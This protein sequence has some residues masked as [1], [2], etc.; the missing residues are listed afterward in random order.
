MGPEDAA[1]AT[2]ARFSCATRALQRGPIYIF[3]IMQIR[4]REGALITPSNFSSA[5]SADRG[6]I[7]FPFYCLTP[8]MH[9]S[10]IARAR[11]FFFS[12]PWN[13]MNNTTR[14]KRHR[15]HIQNVSHVIDLCVTRSPH[16]GWWG[17]GNGVMRLLGRNSLQIS[18]HRQ[19]N[20]CLRRRCALGCNNITRCAY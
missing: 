13:W 9:Y 8:Q 16:F 18:S 12:S 1:A 14:E 4:R 3:V 2:K 17:D 10:S 20:C 19:Q 11:H 5:N 7:N 15:T 6:L